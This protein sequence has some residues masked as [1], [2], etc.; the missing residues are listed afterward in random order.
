MNAAPDKAVIEEAALELGINPAFGEKGLYVAQLLSI[1]NNC[2]S[3]QESS[4]VT[5]DR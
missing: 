5:L 2:Y 1:V 3:W 4:I